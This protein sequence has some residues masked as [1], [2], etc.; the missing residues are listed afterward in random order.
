MSVTVTTTHP[1][2]QKLLPFDGDR[3]AKRLERCQ[4]LLANLGDKRLT[5][6]DKVPYFDYDQATAIAK[7]SNRRAER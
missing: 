7:E 2:H 3:E 6:A 4:R 5:T 1:T